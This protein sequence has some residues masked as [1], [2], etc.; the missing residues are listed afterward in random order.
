MT[1]EKIKE[2]ALKCGAAFYT[3]INDTPTIAFHETEL[4]AFAKELT[5]DQEPVAYL[6]AQGVCAITVH[7]ISELNKRRTSGEFPWS[8]WPTKL[9]TIPP[10]QADRIKELED[11]LT[12]LTTTKEYK[13]S[14]GKDYIY[15]SMKNRAWYFAYKALGKV[16]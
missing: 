12:M 5:G 4:L 2:I 16:K 1:I 8:L 7:M 9:Y 14:Q 13:D 11:A 6:D 3:N 15:E 10:S